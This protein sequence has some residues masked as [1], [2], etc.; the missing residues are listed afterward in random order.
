V[1][2]DLGSSR[3]D[4]RAGEVLDF[5]AYQ[6]RQLELKGLTIR[7]HTDR[8]GSDADNLRVSVRRAEVLRAH[9]IRRGIS[10]SAIRLEPMGERQPLV[11]T[12]DGVR[13]PQN[14][15]AEIFFDI[16]QTR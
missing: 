10:E 9:L 8:A 12:P 13:E 14:R 2:F 15:R 7:A 5:A 6:F 1:F 4:Q 16:P 11:E 3:L